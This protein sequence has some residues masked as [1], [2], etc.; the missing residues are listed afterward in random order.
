MAKRPPFSTR[1]P[2]C[3]AVLLIA[4]AMAGVAW[5][6]RHAVLVSMAQILV[7]ED[8]LSPVELLVVSHAN[9]RT[10]AL[11]AVQL[12]RAHLSPQIA[13]TT[14]ITNPIDDEIRRLGILCLHPTEIARSILER[15]GVASDA[16]VVLP[17]PVDGTET[18]IAA[19]VA[20]ALQSRP[21]SMRLITARSHTARARWLLRRDL[22]PDIRISVGSA[23]F[24][25]FS[26]ASWWQKRDQ[27]REVM[28]EYLRWANTLFLGDPWAR[29]TPARPHQ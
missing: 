19:V 18:E 21:R 26:I 24:D 2:V 9:V 28:S 3:V 12:Y 16:I 25:P 7:D 1:H 13:L 15:S 20:F 10:A 11:E 27:S 23:R 17:D 5:Y 29:R 6:E 8:P 22:P 4:L 14:W